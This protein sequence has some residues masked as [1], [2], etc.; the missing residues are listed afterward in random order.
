MKSF[1]N[2]EPELI[3][4]MSGEKCVCET[5]DEENDAENIVVDV[6]ADV[7]DEWFCCWLVL[8]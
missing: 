2:S 4:A 7:G 5:R 8:F 1:L 3:I 6:V